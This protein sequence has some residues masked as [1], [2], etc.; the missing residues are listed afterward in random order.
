[1]KAWLNTVGGSSGVSWTAQ[2]EIAAE[3]GVPG[4]MVTFADIDG[5][6]RDDYLIAN[7][8]GRIWAWL[9]RRGSGG[10][11]WAAQGEIATGVGV[12]RDQVNLADYNGD[13]RD[14]Y[15]TVDNAGVVNAWTNNGL[16]RKG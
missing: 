14:D 12:A 10:A 16:T 13:R 5:D 8:S 2:G 11:A 9:N 1:M 4:S 3:V 15:L 7:D 6:L